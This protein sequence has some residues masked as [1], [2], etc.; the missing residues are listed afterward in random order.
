MNSGSLCVISDGTMKFTKPSELNDPFDCNPSFDH[1]SIRGYLDSRPDM[2]RRI[3]SA[4]NISIDRLNSD[5]SIL[6]PL[7][8]AIKGGAF[9]QPMSDH[10]GICSLTR[11]PTNFLMWDRYAGQHTGFVVEFNIPIE[12]RDDESPTYDLILSNLVPQEI[13]YCSDRPTINLMEDSETQMKKRFLMKHISW[14]YEEEERCIDLKRRF[15]IHSYN[16]DL[17]LSS[18]IAGSKMGDEEFTD[19]EQLIEATNSYN[20]LSIN[21]FRAELSRTEYAIIVPGFN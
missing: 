6:R 5:S 14:S 15:G 7:E 11:S 3:S 20:R 12:I 13:I 4:L 19:L 10:F 21:L 17:I 9:C 18:V 8:D 16:R 1:Q 2:R